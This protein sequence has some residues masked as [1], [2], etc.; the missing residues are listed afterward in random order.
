MQVQDPR[1]LFHLPVFVLTSLYILK[2]TLEEILE[3]S[4]EKGNFSIVLMIQPE[5]WIN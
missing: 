3:I 1:R 4:R 5:G 2:S